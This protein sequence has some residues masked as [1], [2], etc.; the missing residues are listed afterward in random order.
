M[1]GHSKW[2]NIRIRKS[3]QDA[4]R[5]KLFTKLSKEILLAAKE[6]PDPETNFRLKVA[7][8]RAKDANMPNSNIE[9]LLEKARG[10]SAGD[11]EEISYE[12]YGPN[13]VAILVEAATDNRNRTAAQIRSL[14]SRHGGSLGETGCVTWLFERRGM[15]VCEGEEIEEDDLFMAAVEAGALDVEADGSTY[16]VYTEPTELHKVREALTENGFAPKTV[17]FTMIPK[18]TVSCDKGSAASVM[19]LVEALEDHD[20][21]QNVYANAEIPDELLDELGAGIS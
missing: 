16:T 13:G 17:Q 21:V 15:L 10:G 12:G 5:G 7:I 19:A 2:A 18:N 9:R 1:A 20:D 4:K 11:V 14:F 6:G 8:G 3:K